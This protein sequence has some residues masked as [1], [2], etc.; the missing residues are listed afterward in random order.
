MGVAN[1]LHHVMAQLL[2]STR[3]EYL[4]SSVNN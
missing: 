2:A 3:M 4:S 1:D